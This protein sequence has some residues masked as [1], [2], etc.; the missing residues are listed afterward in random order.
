M[1]ARRWWWV[2]GVADGERQRDGGSFTVPDGA[3][4]VKREVAQEEVQYVR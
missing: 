3:I 2:T 1:V 4:K